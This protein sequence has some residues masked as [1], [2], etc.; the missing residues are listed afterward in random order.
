MAT[1]FGIGYLSHLFTD[2]LHPFLAGDY[3]LISFLVWPLVPAIEYST[4]QNFAAHLRK[5]TLESFVSFEVA[6]GLL[7]F[8]LWLNDGAP[9]FGIVKKIPK[10]VGRKLS[11]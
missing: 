5:L 7:V 4:E 6:L 11:F 8:I 2:A 10:W 3:Y 1:A 9:G